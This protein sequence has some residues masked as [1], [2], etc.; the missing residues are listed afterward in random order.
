MS[1]ITIYIPYLSRTTTKDDI[2][3]VFQV[4][5]QIGS[6]EHIDLL[7]E[8]SNSFCD[9]CR[10]KSDK[11]ERRSCDVCLLRN[12]KKQIGAYIQ[13]NLDMENEIARLILDA[14]GR[15]VFY[16]LRVTRYSDYE[17][18]VTKIW[19]LTKTQVVLPL[20]CDNSPRIEVPPNTPTN[21]KIEEMI[22]K[23]TRFD[24][25]YSD[26]DSELESKRESISSSSSREEESNNEL[27]RKLYEAT[28]LLSIREKQIEELERQIKDMRFFALS[29]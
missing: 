6:V 4:E 15:D 7:T 27:K 20:T 24:L 13:V 28:Q 2:I 23:I 19:C 14:F 12:K 16:N 21:S 29:P 11:V 9:I 10:W 17:D 26:Y 8:N 3:N 5:H 22:D 25:I 1:I 18:R